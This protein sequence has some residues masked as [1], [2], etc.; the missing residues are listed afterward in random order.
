MTADE[1]Q[2]DPVA[3]IPEAIEEIRAGRM[4][5]IMDDEDRENEGDLVIAADKATPEAVNFM[6]IH[7]RGLICTPI[8]R[9]RAKELDLELMVAPSRNETPHG[10]SF[11]VSVEARHGVT[12]G[13]SAHDR[14]TTIRTIIDPKSK[15]DDLVR[16]GHT[17]PLVA[18][19]GGVLRRTGQTEASVDLAR[20]AGLTPAAVVCEIMK[21]DGTMARRPQLE[22][23]A[24]EHGI[25][26]C[27]VAELVRYR[28]KEESLVERVAAPRLPTRYG[29][30]RIIAYESIIDNELHLAMVMGEIEPDDPVLVRVHSACLTGEVFS[31]LRCDCQAQVQRALEMIGREGKGVL[32]YLRQE[33]R[34]IGLKA[35]LRA[36]ELQ[37]QGHDTV[38]ANVALGFPPDKRDYGIG[39]Q[40][41]KDVGVGKLRYLTNNPQKFVAINGY[42]L[43]IVERVPIEI[44]TDSPDTLRY[45][46][47]KKEKLGHLFDR[48]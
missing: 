1:R 9:E 27:T 18:A 15:P 29:E 48:V 21:E 5:I 33:G 30:F 23:F 40:I 39:A 4:I 46:R 42:G 34:G 8:T 35:K 37:D 13:I 43:E 17:F 2:F 25:K 7:G 20:M 10:T 36:Y 24:R 22:R 19:R 32:V 16:P 31:S 41:L 28:M 26:I 44:E 38:E 45:L 6:A 3:T 11:T 12:T 14:C 47:T